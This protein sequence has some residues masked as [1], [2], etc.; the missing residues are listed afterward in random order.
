[1]EMAQDY[2]LAK[3]DAPSCSHQNY[4]KL[5]ALSKSITIDPYNNH[6]HPLNHHITIAIIVTTSDSTLDGLELPLGQVITIVFL[7]S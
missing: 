6:N 4:P 2:Q 3:Q 5:I 1:M 7:R